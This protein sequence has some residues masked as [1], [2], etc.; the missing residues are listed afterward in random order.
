MEDSQPRPAPRIAA[1]QLFSEDDLIK[2]Y[3]GL[4]DNK[5]YKSMRNALKNVNNVLKGLL[6]TP[7]FRVQPSAAAKQTNTS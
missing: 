2:N 3:K 1:L 7:V 4:Q 6:S 5:S